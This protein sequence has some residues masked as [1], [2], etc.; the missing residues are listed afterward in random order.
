MSVNSTHHNG[1]PASSDQNYKLKTN[2]DTLQQYLMMKTAIIEKVKQT[3]LFPYLLEME[4]LVGSI[5]GIKASEDPIEKLG[6]YLRIQNG[7]NEKLKVDFTREELLDWEVFRLLILLPTDYHTFN[8]FEV[9]I[10]LKIQNDNLS[11]VLF[12][13]INDNIID[14]ERTLLILDKDDRIQD[15]KKRIR[16][17]GK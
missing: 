6:P 5:N 17:N 4:Y 7:I 3:P 15:I 10:I 13:L 1:S 12:G 14:A 16:N 11:F 2:V 9:F 8:E